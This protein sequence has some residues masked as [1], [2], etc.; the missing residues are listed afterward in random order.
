M[1][2]VGTR[3][4]GC[5]WY[6]LAASATMVPQLGAGTC[7]PK[8]RNASPDV[9]ITATAATRVAC[10]TMGPRIRAMMWRR[11]ICQCDRPLTRAASM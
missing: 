9:R 4:H 8:P 11:M 5:C 10:T 1:P 2:P 3:N 7:T 6:W